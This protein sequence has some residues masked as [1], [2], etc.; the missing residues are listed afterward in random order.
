MQYDL[1][2]RGGLL[3]QKRSEA[4]AVDGYL[5]ALGRQNT[6]EAR[7][8]IVECKNTGRMKQTW[9]NWPHY[10]PGLKVRAE[11]YPTDYHSEHCVSV[12]D[13]VSNKDQEGA[14]K[15]DA[16][17]ERGDVEESATSSATWP[18]FNYPNRRKWDWQWWATHTMKNRLQTRMQIKCQ[19]VEK[20]SR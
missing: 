3:S 2:R 9:G 14:I 7:R 16:G 5:Q 6:L 4:G 8:S 1:A 18:G 20:K 13:V 15:N 11:G 17:K 19:G 10:P 12:A